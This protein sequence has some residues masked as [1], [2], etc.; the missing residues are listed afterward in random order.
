MSVHKLT[1]DTTTSMES[2]RE[3]SKSDISATVELHV[4]VKSIE[5]PVSFVYILTHA[6]ACGIFIHLS[7]VDLFGAI[8]YGIAFHL[9]G[10]F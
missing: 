9:D 2:Y 7:L 5:R 10:Q 4:M 1:H 8:R 3:V 6:I